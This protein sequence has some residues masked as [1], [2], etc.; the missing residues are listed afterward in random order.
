MRSGPSA[1][2]SS[3]CA[4][5]RRVGAAVGQV[6]DRR[7][8]RPV[9]RRVRRVDEAGQALRQPVIAPRLPA[10]AVHALLHHDPVAV[11]GD[12]EAVQVELEPVLHRGAVDLGDEPARRRQRG[13]VEAD[14]LADRHQLVRRLARMPAAP[15][16]DM[17]AELAGERRQPALQR[18]DHAGGD[19]GRV[20][21]HP[22]HRAERLE[23]E[24]MGEPAQQLVAPVMV[25]DR[26]GDHRAEP[27]HALGEPRRHAAAMQRQVGAA[28]PLRHYAAP[29]GGSN[30]RTGG[31][32]PSNRSTSTTAIWPAQ[33]CARRDVPISRVST[34]GLPCTQGG[35]CRRPD[36]PGRTRRRSK[37]ATM[38]GAMRRSAPR[39]RGSAE[40]VEHPYDIAVADAA[41]CGVVW[42]DADRLAALTFDARLVAPKSNWLCNRVAGWL[43]IR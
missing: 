43:A 21:V 9:D 30:A 2:S 26:L 24:R 3:S 6:D 11:V 39:R 12:D 34:F 18:A 1:C 22:H 14:A 41:R 35:C 7:P 5:A 17:E 31:N 29:G 28:R 10:L 13:A 15:A 27:R 37:V 36:R 42:V 32:G 20:P 4:G 25:D 33:P 8:A 40:I 38:P 19:A 23:P 16:A